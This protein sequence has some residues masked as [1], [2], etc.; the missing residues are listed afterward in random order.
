VKALVSLQQAFQ[1]YV[2]HGEHGVVE[3][4][5]GGEGV[6]PHQRLRIY[7]DAYRMRL[8]EALATDYEALR[9]LMG[10]EPFKTACRAYVEATPSPFRNLRWYGAGLPEFLRA[11]PPWA[12]RPMLYELALFEWTLAL[13]FDAPDHVAVRFEDLASLSPEAWPEIGFVLHP[14]AHLLE[15]RTNAPALRKA[16]DAGEA[17]PEAVLADDP[18]AWL[19]WRQEL[20]ACFRSLNEPESWALKAVQDGANFTA[21]CEGLCR[22]LSPEEAAA[23]AAGLLRQWVDADLIGDLTA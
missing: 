13:A 7:F 9:A 15:L 21:L 16:A 11:T 1:K 6:D 10:D 22:W 2:L 18:K 19:V 12:E 3:R 23:H 20:T 8:V 17:L 4:I 5:A 14:S